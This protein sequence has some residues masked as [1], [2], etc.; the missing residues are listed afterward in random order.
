M[1]KGL[2]YFRLTSPYEGDITK[3]CGLDGY[4]VDNNF[5]TLEGRDIKSVNVNGNELTITLMNGETISALNAFAGFTKDLCFDFDAS[6]GILYIKRNGQTQEISGFATS[7]AEKEEIATD[8]TI[9]GDGKP[10]KP[11][12]ISPMY[13]TGQYRPAKKVI[14]TTKCEYLPVGD[15]VMPGDRY[16]TIEDYSQYG[17]LYDYD[18]VK[19]IA[20]DLNACHSAWRIPTKEDWDDMLNAVEPCKED[21]DHESAACNR[22]FGRFAGKFLKTRDYWKLERSCHD[23]CDDTCISYDDDACGNNACACGRPNPCT[24]THCG[25]YGTCHHR[26]HKYPNRGIDKFGFGVVPAGYADD[27]GLIGYYQE[28]AWFWT[29][30]NNQFTTA[31]TKRFEYD[32]SSVYQDVISTNYSLSLR[33]IKDYNGENYLEK[34]NI[35]GVSY[36]TVLMPSIKKGHT[37]WTSV[38]AAFSNKCYHPSFPNNGMGLPSK[39]VFYTNEWDGK[40]WLKKLIQ[41]GECVVIMDAPDGDHG[42]EYRLINGDLISVNSVMYEKVMTSITPTIESIQ[43]KIDRETDRAIAREDAIE[44]NLNNEISRSTQADADLQ[45]AID[46]NKNDV[47]ASIAEINE[48]LTATDNKVD[49]VKT[50]LDTFKQDTQAKFDELNQNIE[51][52]VNQLKAAIEAEAT[53]RANADAELQKKDEELQQNITAE[54]EERKA[55]D[56]QLQQQIDQVKETEQ[57]LSDKI[58]QEISDRTA[59]D[60]QLS[61]NI[62]ELSTTVDTLRKD[63]DG[64][65]DSAES[66]ISGLKEALAQEQQERTE[67]DN[68]LTDSIAA[69]DSQIIISEGSSFDPKTGV[70]TLKSKG[71]DNDIILQL[72]LD[73]G[74]I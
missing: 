44:Q 39:K 64:H 24:P 31:Y 19:Q 11:M 27:G 28:R 60:Q 26:P 4:E 55:N 49:E 67:K 18:A 1:S 63:F 38:N 71:G 40:R 69:T 45:A 66:E 13:K 9:L 42:V 21:R 47:D 29:A 41:E 72:S 5:Y 33:L 73:F 51:A 25:E 61:D 65:V 23:H 2:T 54:A 8:S 15:K 34:E 62:D 14:D 30:S 48:H 59:A 7:F 46:Q 32:K 37:I 35:L 16:I 22:Y 57:Q 36:P 17:F 6:K 50:D 3:N 68:E 43:A 53:E 70:I 12:G 20:C 52:D 74:D 10:S 58:D 56:D